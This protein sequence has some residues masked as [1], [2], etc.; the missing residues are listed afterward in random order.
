[1]LRYINPV[2]LSHHYMNMDASNP[3]AT[4]AAD[5]LRLADLKPE[6]LPGAVPMGLLE[7]EVR[8]ESATRVSRAGLTLCH[9]EGHLQFGVW[10]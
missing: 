2:N 9:K 4:V 7:G 8:K 10:P 5:A 1:M 6:E 3:T